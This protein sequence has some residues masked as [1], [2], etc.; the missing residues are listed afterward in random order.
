MTEAINFLPDD[1]PND[2]VT[3]MATALK[4]GQQAQAQGALANVDLNNAPTIPQAIQNSIRAGAIEQGKTLSDLAFTRSM[5]GRVGALADYALKWAGGGGQE[6]GPPLTPV[7]PGAQPGAGA[8]VTPGE[9][10]A[11]GQPAAA[12]TPPAD[13]MNPQMAAQAAHLHGQIAS[14]LTAIRAITD[15]AARKV[16]M[17]QTE[18]KYSQ[19][20][21]PD[22]VKREL[23]D[24]NDPNLGQHLD[25]LIA[26][27]GGYASNLMAHA[28]GQPTTPIVPPAHHG[29]GIMDLANNPGAILGFEAMKPYGLDTSGLLTASEKANEP[30]WAKAAEER[31]AYGIKSATE[32]AGLDNSGTFDATLASTGGK[33]T[34]PS[35]AAAVEFAAAHPGVLGDITPYAKSAQEK[36]GALDAE[37]PRTTTMVS[38]TKDDGTE[39][40]VPMT[41]AQELQYTQTG[42][43]PSAN[44]AIAG[45]IGA[46]GHIGA[47]S[48]AQ[49]Q[50]AEANAK[51]YASGIR[52]A[53]DLATG[54]DPKIQN[55]IAVA[56]RIRSLAA[57]G[58][59][60]AYNSAIA[61]FNKYAAPFSPNAA[62]RTAT[63]QGLD[64]EMSNLAKS[65]LS[66][67]GGSTIRNMGEFAAVTASAGHLADT[68]QA[69]IYSALKAEA[70]MNYADRYNKFA[71]KFDQD[72][73]ELR[74]NGNAPATLAAAWNADPQSR[75]GPLADPV[76]ATE[77]NLD[78]KPYLSEPRTD[79]AGRVYKQW[80]PGGGMKPVVVRV[81]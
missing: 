21:P 4:A 23:G 26:A 11:G 74:G 51:E 22:V 53:Q 47:P 68:P 39:I 49:Q 37:N 2:Y 55:G 66:G 35:K 8:P 32:Q 72:H 14:D 67:V 42:Q 76:W 44:P 1:K 79:S 5:Q 70:A 61:D 63:V 34:F 58:D 71:V 29:P 27:H 12:G 57:G 24:P 16:A 48:A 77:K 52:E 18:A 73:P 60:G 78:G 25:T 64:Q 65:A 41:K 33:M 80:D 15:P 36:G 54:K 30:E 28:N 31:H 69:K 9:P 10:A 50:A 45:A 46:G 43:L 19:F 38:V 81:K 6:G 7:S 17:A 20:L 13:G 59:R 62:A 75:L 3:P 40:K 56:Q